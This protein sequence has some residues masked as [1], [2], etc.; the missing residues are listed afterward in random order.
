MKIISLE[1]A[2]K[3]RFSDVSIALGTFDGLHLGHMTLINAVK[4]FSGTS[5]VF[6][7]NSLPLDLFCA[8]HKPMRLFTL[9]EKIDAFHKT[10]IDY[11]CITSFDKKFACMDKDVFSAMIL[12]VFSPKN[13]VAG[14]NYTYG[15]HA[16]GNAD[17]LEKYGKE[18]GCNVD[19]ISPVIFD[20]EPISATRIRECIAAGSVEKAN[21][22]LGYSY[23]ITG[24][25]GKGKGLGSKLGFPTANI[26]VAKEKIIPLRGVYAVDVA[27][28]QHMYKGVCNI[29]VKPTVS[30]GITET[31]E[32][33]V[34]SLYEDIYGEKVS[35]YFN[36]RIRDEKKFNNIDELKAQIA[37]DIY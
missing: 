13:I 20:G 1:Q 27:V 23:S 7:F 21:Q 32:V 30:S 5:A 34:V 11:L 28:G 4:N 35:V 29:G 15:R 6:T 36:K 12:N 2:K 26:I 9:E 16:L 8:D 18:H 31:I 19:I 24:T 33:Y 37:Y 17:T 25:V 3:I 10:G 14:Y 22:L